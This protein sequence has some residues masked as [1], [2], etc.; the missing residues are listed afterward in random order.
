MLRFLLGTAVGS[1]AYMLD[2]TIRFL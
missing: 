2:I 1:V